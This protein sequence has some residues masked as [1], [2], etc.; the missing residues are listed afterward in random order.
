MTDRARRSVLIWGCL[1]AACG[2]ESRAEPSDADGAVIGELDAGGSADDAAAGDAGSSMKHVLDRS[3]FR[4]VGTSDPLDYAVPEMWACRPDISPSECDSDL[5]ASLI[6][7]DGTYALEAHQVAEEPAF[8]CFYVYPTVLLSG[9]AQMVDFSDDGVKLVD[10]ALLT[11]GARFSSMCRM[12]APL[13]RQVGLASGGTIVAG[14]DPALGLEDVRAAFAYYLEHLNQG[15]DFVLIGHSQGTSML[16]QLAVR[17]IDPDDKAD[18]RARLLSALLIGFAVEVPAGE[19]VGGTFENL[20]LCSAPAERG[21]VISYAS[22]AADREPDDRARFG[23]TS[24]A[25][26]EVAC[27]NPALLANNTGRFR[28]S[29]FRKAIENASFF[30][31]TPLPSDLPS[32]FAVYHDLFRGECAAK[33]DARFLRIS[34]DA[35]EGDARTPPWRQAT[36]EGIGFGL[37]LVDYQIPMGDL[38]EAVR[39]QAEAAR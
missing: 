25:G 3:R 20:P 9:A 8:D 5:S 27:V 31:D 35:D 38:L 37:H 14:A 7:P 19:K 29:Y 18:V 39:L 23:R 24:K 26:M 6:A 32:P 11:Q 22:F 10:D 15:R 16:T 12:Y 13:Y 36:V 21:C 28:A 2:S 33:G 17:D 4:D 30:P 34:L 1:V